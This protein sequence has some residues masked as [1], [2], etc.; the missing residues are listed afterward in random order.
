M[1]SQAAESD[2]R[3]P[4]VIVTGGVASG[5]RIF[6]PYKTVDEAVAQWQATA[7]G[8]VGFPCSVLLHTKTRNA[9][10]PGMVNSCLSDVRVLSLWNPWP[11]LGP[12]GSECIGRA[13]ARAVLEPIAGSSR[14]G[15]RNGH[16]STLEFSLRRFREICR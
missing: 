1:N 4:A 8:Y 13:W 12:A 10:E 9:A 14:R 2:T 6:G 16:A 5:F 7:L 11:A 3:G 15:L